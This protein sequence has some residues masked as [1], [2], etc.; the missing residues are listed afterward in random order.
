VLEKQERLEFPEGD[1]LGSEGGKFRSKTVEVNTLPPLRLGWEAIS[2]L[3]E[4]GGNELAK[5]LRSRKELRV[6][7][8]SG[9][10][11]WRSNGERQEKRL[12]W[13][14]R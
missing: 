9:G 1:D 8:K 6:P 14:E 7:L 11:A 5:R 2:S 10:M 4:G 3:I 13:D 12:T